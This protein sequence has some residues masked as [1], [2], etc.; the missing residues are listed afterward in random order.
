MNHSHDHDHSPVHTDHHSSLDN[1]ESNILDHSHSRF[2][3]ANEY[4]NDCCDSK[5]K[6]CCS[7]EH[8]N[9]CRSSHPPSQSLDH[10]HSHDYTANHDDDDDCCSGNGA[11]CSP[12]NNRN[13]HSISNQIIDH[14]HSHSHHFNT[15]EVDCCSGD[16]ECCSS[17]SH[18]HPLIDHSHSHDHHSIHLDINKRITK[19][20]LNPPNTS[21]TNN[22]TSTDKDNL[23]KIDFNEEEKENV[24]LLQK[25]NSCD[26]S[27]SVPHAIQVTRF[28]IANLCCAGE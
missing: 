1:I 4:H 8:D 3:L 12:N 22:S 10:S 23:F 26:S 24:P 11:C 27:S 28:K 13:V 16:Q 14:S 17:T 25:C 19:S 20:K 9:A 7:G 15:A 6:N 5:I 18:P 21:S 2:H